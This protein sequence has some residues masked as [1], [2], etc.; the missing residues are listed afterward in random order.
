[1]NLGGRIFNLLV[2]VG[3]IVGIAVAAG[4]IWHWADGLPVVAA[5]AVTLL[6]I[7]LSSAAA[8]ILLLCGPDCIPE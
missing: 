3:M 1:M 7:W 8:L 5:I 2:M 6:T 4:S